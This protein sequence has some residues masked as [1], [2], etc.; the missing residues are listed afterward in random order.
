MAKEPDICNCTEDAGHM[1]KKKN[2]IVLQL[3]A[4]RGRRLAMDQGRL[5]SPRPSL[6]QIYGTR[7]I[8][9]PVTSTS[10]TWTLTSSS[11]KTASPLWTTRLWMSWF[12]PHPPHPPPHSFL[13]GSLLLP[14]GRA[15]CPRRA[16]D[17][18][19]APQRAPVLPPWE[20]LP[21]LPLLPPTHW[22][23]L[24]STNFWSGPKWRP[25]R[26]G[27]KSKVRTSCAYL[28]FCV[29]VCMC[30]HA[31]VCV[32]VCT[33]ICVQFCHLWSCLLFS[34]KKVW[35]EWLFMPC[36]SV[37]YIFCGRIMLTDMILLNWQ[38]LQKFGLYVRVL[39]IFSADGRTTSPGATSSG[40]TPPVSPLPVH[41]DFTLTEQDI[42]LSSV[43]GNTPSQAAPPPVPLCWEGWG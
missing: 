19:L 30:A 1:E 21:L 25:Q 43:P 36:S 41:V 3:Q 26:M 8:P 6:A 16:P 39:W 31:F 33:Y 20:C 23:S 18:S 37:L 28:S 35:C 38:N 11:Q 2:W 22:Q 15:Q 29:C 10:S 5:T 17:P 7:P 24:L 13:P 40:S 4:P 32:C 12:P 42:A 14:Q 27:Y 9:A 34:W